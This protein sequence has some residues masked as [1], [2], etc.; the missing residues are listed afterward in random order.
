MPTRNLSS[1]TVLEDVWTAYD[2]DGQ[3]FWF[4]HK[5]F[6]NRDDQQWESYHVNDEHFIATRASGKGYTKSLRH[7]SKLTIT[8]FVKL[9]GELSP[10]QE[11]SE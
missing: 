1:E 9:E 5:P 4:R 6:L 8:A 7:W 3:L 10:E 11:P 2:G